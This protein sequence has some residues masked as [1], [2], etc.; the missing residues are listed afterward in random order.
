MTFISNA[1]V[2]GSLAIALFTGSPASARAEIVG[3][4]MSPG[5]GI[6]GVAVGVGSGVG[7]HRHGRHY[8]YGHCSKGKALDR[9]AAMGV[10]KPHVSG[11]SGGRISVRGIR[12]GQPVRVTM[13][14]QSD[15]CAVRS[16][17]YL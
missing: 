6:G 3:L 17:N 5:N 1:L 10:K 14:R 2:A 16:V 8:A 12:K 11:V 13:Y 7:H 9:A 4:W 15:S